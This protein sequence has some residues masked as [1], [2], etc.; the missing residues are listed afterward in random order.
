[1]ITCWQAFSPVIFLVS[2]LYYARY[3]ASNFDLDFEINVQE[4]DAGIV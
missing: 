3:Y 1:M 4:M 2:R